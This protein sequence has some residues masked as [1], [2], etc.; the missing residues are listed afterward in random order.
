MNG[1]VRRE[2]ILQLLSTGDTPVSGTELARRLGVSRQI[3]VQ[4]IALIRA[5]GAEI[6]STNKG[7]ILLEKETA[8]R[9]FKVI[10]TDEQ[11]RQELELIID[12]GGSVEDVFV[13]HKVYGVIRGELNLHSRL[14]INRYI[15]DIKSGK[16]SLLKNTTSGYHYHTVTADSEATLDLIQNKLQEAGFLARLQDYEPVDFWSRKPS[17]AQNPTDAVSHT[18]SR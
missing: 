16:S 11:V 10:H 4:D 18:E 3:I 13:Y 7:Y 12:N 2:K 5:K 17:A 8:S 6:Y 1:E 9:V 14:D 15:A